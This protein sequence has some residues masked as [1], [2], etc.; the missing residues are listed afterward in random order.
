MFNS[1]DIKKELEEKNLDSNSFDY[2]YKYLSTKDL[3]Y[4]LDEYTERLLDG[5]PVQYIIGNACF[6]GYDFK[7][8]KNT[9]IPRFETELLVE[10][11]IKY[12]NKYFSGKVDILDI[13]TGSGCIAITLNKLVYSN[14][15]A[16]DI[17]KEAIVIAKENN[18]L[19]NTNVNF[20][21]SDVFSNV[22]KKYDV[23]ISNPPYISFDEDIMDI[24]KNNEPYIALYAENNGLYYY[25]K[26]LK[27][28]KNYL[29]DRFF[30]A[31]EIG[32]LQAKDIIDM[33]NKYFKDV[34][35]SVEKDYSDKDRFIFID[36]IN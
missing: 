19:N 30:I 1:N 4:K 20:M 8:N 12:I 36:N 27:E 3:L 26:I 29:N 33:I 2:L 6:Y 22:N 35:I 11:T 5:E 31:F 15:D 13:G 10:K 14:V 32:Y 34:N 18:I 16:I 28:C 24:V 7:V 23:I 21:I 9:L 25:N 17:S